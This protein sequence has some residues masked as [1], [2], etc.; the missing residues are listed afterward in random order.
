MIATVDFLENSQIITASRIQKF[1]ARMTM[2][3]EWPSNSLLIHLLKASESRIDL[4][5]FIPLVSFCTPELEKQ[6]FSDIS[7]LYRK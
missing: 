3:Q 7:I 1:N 5:H 4:S 6:R 2:N